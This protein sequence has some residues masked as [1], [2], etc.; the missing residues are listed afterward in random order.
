MSRHTSRI[1]VKYIVWFLW[2]L[3]IFNWKEM[4]LFTFG[5]STYTVSHGAA[6]AKLSLEIPLLYQGGSSQSSYSFSNL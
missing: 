2:H 1:L 3:I 4:F 6:A 5:F